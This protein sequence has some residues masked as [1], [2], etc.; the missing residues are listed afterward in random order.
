MSK[1]AT[2]SEL[3]RDAILRDPRTYQDLAEAAGC[4]H[5]QLARF[6]RS[7][8]TLRLPT[9]DGLLKA[10]GLECRLVRARRKGS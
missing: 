5:G 1:H 8:R 9:V 10:L 6:V 2:L 4:T 3:L 7:E